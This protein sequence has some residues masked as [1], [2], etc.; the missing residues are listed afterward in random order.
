[1]ASQKDTSSLAKGWGKGTPLPL[2]IFIVHRR[3]DL[4]IKVNKQVKVLSICRGA[5]IINHLFF[6]DDSMLFCKMNFETNLEVQKLLLWTWTWKRQPWFLVTIPLLD[7]KKPLE[8]FGQMVPYISLKDILIFLAWLANWRESLFLKLN[9]N[10]GK[11]LVWKE[12]LLSHGSMEV[13]LKV[14]A[15]AIPTY[16][17]SCVELLDNL[18][19][20]LKNMMA[21]FW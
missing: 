6:V 2:P 10:C 11:L 8:P 5:P 4:F 20:E 7:A 13:L 19:K 21:P 15:L 17:R 18:C 3:I 16:A 9:K 12:T 1:M 14:V